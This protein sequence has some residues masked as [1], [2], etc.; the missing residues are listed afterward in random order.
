M[1]GFCSHSSKVEVG[2]AERQAESAIIAIRKNAM[3]IFE[4]FDMLNHFLL[5]GSGKPM[6][7]FVAFVNLLAPFLVTR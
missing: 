4:F 6:S 3:M 7:L 2:F 5:M 1:L